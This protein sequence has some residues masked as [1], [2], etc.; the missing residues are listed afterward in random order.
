M[1]HDNTVRVFDFGQDPRGW[2]YLA[3]ELLVGETLHDTI[4]ARWVKRQGM[5]QEEAVHVGSSILQSLAEAH[6]AGLVHRDLKPQ[7]IF[8]H[9]RNNAQPLVKVLDFGIA[10]SVDFQLTQGDCALGT[11]TYMSPEQ[12][13]S[14]HL[15]GRS[16]L[17]SVGCLLYEMVSGQPPF[18]ADSVLALLFKQVTMPPPDLRDIALTPITQAFL[19]VIEKAL[20][21]KAAHRYADASAMRAALQACAAFADAD[22]RLAS[23]SG[24]TQACATTPEPTQTMAWRGDSGIFEEKP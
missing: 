22:V 5:T 18:W 20:S 23:N 15:D 4:Q 9:Q 21:K 7:N 6:E 10:R 8:L 13:V 14:D 17:Y 24:L 16:D 19:A 1:K 11:P 12:C 2:Y 3:M